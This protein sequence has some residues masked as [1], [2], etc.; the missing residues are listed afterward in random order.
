ME[1]RV[2]HLPFL[3]KANVLILPKEIL[4]FDFEQ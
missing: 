2:I 3:L 4:Q 1:D